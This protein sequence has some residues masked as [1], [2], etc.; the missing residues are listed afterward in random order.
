MN[1]F[2]IFS[3]SLEFSQLPPIVI[4][5]KEKKNSLSQVKIYQKLLH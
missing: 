3:K 5:K 1:G 2:R 4:L